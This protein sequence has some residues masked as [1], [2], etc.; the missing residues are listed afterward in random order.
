MELAQTDFILFLQEIFYLPP[1][2]HIRN[3]ADKHKNFDQYI[4]FLLQESTLTLKT[5]NTL[6][7]ILTFYPS[8]EFREPNFEPEKD[9]LRSVELNSSRVATF[10]NSLDINPTVNI[11]ANLIDQRL[12]NFRFISEHITV[13][14][15]LPHMT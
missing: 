3:V 12:I 5:K 8:I 9:L 15:T 4:K 2:K 7:Q 11:E 14:Y 6:S 10:L 1:I 13:N